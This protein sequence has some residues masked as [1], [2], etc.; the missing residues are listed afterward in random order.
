MFDWVR[1]SLNDPSP[2]DDEADGASPSEQAASALSA[3]PVNK[4]AKPFIPGADQIQN[5]PTTYLEPLPWQI[6]QRYLSA[7]EP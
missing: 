5:Q 4:E 3:A 6:E 2:D 7:D 1:R